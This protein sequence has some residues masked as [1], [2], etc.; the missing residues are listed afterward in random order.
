MKYK[1]LNLV[2]GKIKSNS[3]NCTWEI[4]KWSK[5]IEDIDMCNS[6]YHCS[7][8]ILGAMSFVS[9]EVLAIVETKGK[10]EKQKDKEVYESMQ[11][12]KAYKWTKKDSVSLSIYSAELVLNNF[13]KLYP[14]D[15][16]PRKAIEAAKKV[17]ENDTEEN[18]SAARSAWSA[19]SA[20][21][22]QQGQQQSQQHGQQQ[23]ARS[24]ESAARSAAIKKINT[25][26]VNHIKDMDNI[27]ESK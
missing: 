1:F 5:P 16:R 19:E 26:L 4:G 27:K 7:K 15:D 6:G 14:D 21:G 25:W 22:Q 9:G 18:R 17:L 23:S 20:I 24:A 13:E 11:I 2:K 10:S 8:T 12:V 3:G